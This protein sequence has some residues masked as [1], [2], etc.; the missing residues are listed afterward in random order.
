MSRGRVQR[1]REARR[2]EERRRLRD[3]ADQVAGRRAPAPGPPEMGREPGGGRGEGE[4][5]S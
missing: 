3:L 4:A 1:E 5:L 2:K